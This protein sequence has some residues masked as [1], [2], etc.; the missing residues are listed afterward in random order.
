MAKRKVM[1]MPNSYGSI[2][3]LSGNRRKPFMACVNPRINDKGT[4]SYDVL[5]YFEDRAAAMIALA[6]YNKN[7][8]DLSG[9]ST[10][11]AEVYEAYFKDKYAG[12]KKFSQASM[13]S[14]RAAFKNCSALHNKTFNSLKHSDLQKVVDD[15][16]LKHASIELIVTLFKQMYR[17]AMREEI[18]QKDAAAYIKIN[19]ADDDEHGIR[20]SD[21]DVTKL[22]AN[23]DKL[24]ARVLLI[25]LYTGWRATELLELPKTDMNL[26]EWYMIGG[27]KT[28]AGKNRIVPIHPRIRSFVKELYDAPGDYFLSPTAKPRSYGFLFTMIKEGLPDCDIATAYTVHDCRHTFSSWLNDAAVPPV[29]CDR[30]MGHSGKTLDEKVYIHKTL[31]QLHSEIKKI[32]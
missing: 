5:G 12:T 27:K 1:R 10:T 24:Y 29:I 18:V 23:T 13:V 26:D 9:R 11:F 17:F 8:Y 2:K 14:T 31:E 3:K 6:E 22:W 7:P 16:P 19:I 25:Y 4:Y 28:K 15:C 32:P 20:W 21:E 30:L